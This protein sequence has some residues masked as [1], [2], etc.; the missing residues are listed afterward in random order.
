MLRR[1][2]SRKKSQ[3]PLNKNDLKLRLWL[4]K[5]LLRLPRPTKRDKL[6]TLLSLQL[7]QSGT[8]TWPKSLLQKPRQRRLD[9]TEK[10]SAPSTNKRKLMR[11]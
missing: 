5:L 1:T 4:L 6:Q 3:L 9:K 8:Q 2:S 10:N 11:K 7:K